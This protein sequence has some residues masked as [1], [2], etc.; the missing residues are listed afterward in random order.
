MLKTPQHLGVF[1]WYDYFMQ[2]NQT[3]MNFGLIAAVITVMGLLF[4]VRKWPKG[5]Q[6]TFSQHSAAHKAST[7]YY[8]ALFAVM[9]PLLLLFFIKWFIP[10]FK[11]S[12]W[13][14][15]LIVLSAATQFTCTL[16]PESG[17][18]KSKYHRLLA[19]CSAVLL[20]PAMY[21]LI[22]SGNITTSMTMLAFTMLGIM[23]GITAFLAVAKGAHKYLL[24]LQAG[25]FACFFV[26]ILGI[27]YI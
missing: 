18:L 16:V 21:I 20:L 12:I 23:L 15:I 8:S 9:L 10:T 13:F 25:Y 4:L 11:L 26:A 24:F 14:T 2:A 22:V 17:G 1:L 3:Y 6:Y 27:T 5:S 19:G 7:I